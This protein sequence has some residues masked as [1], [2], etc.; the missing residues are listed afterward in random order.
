[1]KS[2]IWRHDSGVK[3]GQG[4]G[5]TSK[6]TKGLKSDAEGKLGV[7]CQEKLT[8]RI[9]AYSSC[10]RQGFHLTLPFEKCICFLWGFLL[11]GQLSNGLFR[12]IF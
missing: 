8:G 3:S 9:A 10:A 12:G 6:L 5:K 7:V 1:L 4:Q 11:G 2:C